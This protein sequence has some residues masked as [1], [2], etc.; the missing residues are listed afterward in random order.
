LSLRRSLATIFYTTKL[1]LSIP[2]MA[3]RYY[4]RRRKA[5]DLFKRELTASG[6]SARDAEEVAEVY[7]FKMREILRLG[8][9]LGKK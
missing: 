5:R 2:G 9:A 6:M 8:R 4:F 1:I 3:L 7:P